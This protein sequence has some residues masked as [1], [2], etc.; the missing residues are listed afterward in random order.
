[1]TAYI[2]GFIDQT[3]LYTTIASSA[4]IW[5]ILKHNTKQSTTK[6]PLRNQPRT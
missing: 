4:Y 3:K 5:M 6:I 2:I 1:M